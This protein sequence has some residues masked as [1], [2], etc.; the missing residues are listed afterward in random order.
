[1]MQARTLSLPSGRLAYREAGAGPAIVLLHG[2]SSGAPSWEPL[3]GA[4]PGY[5]LLAW[6][7]PGYGDSAPLATEEPGAAD[8]ADRLE[9]WL[10]ALAVTDAVLVGHSLGALMAAAACALNP[11]RFRA[12]VLADPARGYKHGGPDEQDRVY[13][14]RWPRLAELGAEG[15]AAERAGRLLRQNPDPAALDR[16][17]RGIRRLNLDGFRQANWM[18]AHDD[19]ADWWRQVPAVAAQVVCGDEDRITTP[20]AVR[21]LAAELGLPYQ[22]I[23]LA[24]HASYIDAPG[25][26]A[27]AVTDFLRRL[28][29]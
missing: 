10:T 6:D 24:G 14:S 13:R 28:D 19:L 8:Y 4:L 25:H 17:R 3:A 23:A 29:E 11:G 2:I 22:G 1:M 16:V 7:A 27:R 5:R 12:L 15:F 18:L 9:E 21:A 20:D 26:F